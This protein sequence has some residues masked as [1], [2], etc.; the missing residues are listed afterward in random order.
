MVWV[1]L[2]IIKGHWCLSYWLKDKILKGNKAT[3]C[4]I[5]NKVSFFCQICPFMVF[6]FKNCSEKKLFL[7]SRKVSKIQD[8]RSVSLKTSQP[9]Y[10]LTTIHKQTTYDI[11]HFFQQHSTRIGFHPELSRNTI[12]PS[13]VSFQITFYQGNGNMGCRVSKGGIQN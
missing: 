8:W 1:N 10:K 11:Y 12:F 3:K 7:W 2:I 6:C 9:L 4:K 13:D 5:Q